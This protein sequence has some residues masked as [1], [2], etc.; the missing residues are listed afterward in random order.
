MPSQDQDGDDAQAFIE[1]SK[2]S[3]ARKW[4]LGPRLCEEA[5]EFSHGFNRIQFWG[6]MRYFHWIFWFTEHTTAEKVSCGK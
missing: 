3:L 1:A 6:I 2:R 5:A 4:L